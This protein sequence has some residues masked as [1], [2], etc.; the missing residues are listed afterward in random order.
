VQLTFLNLF[1]RE[2][3]IDNEY[4]QVERL[5]HQAELAVNVNNPLHEEGS[6]GVLDFSLD[7]D[8]GEI[9]RVDAQLLFLCT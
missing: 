8:L 4:S 9:V 2:V 7:L 6:A 1:D 5:G 3:P